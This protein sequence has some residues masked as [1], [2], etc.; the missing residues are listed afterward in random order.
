MLARGRPASDAATFRCGEVQTRRASDPNEGTHG[1]STASGTKRASEEGSEG[2]TQ[3]RTQ[4]ERAAPDDWER[5]RAIRLQALRDSPDA[6]W[7][8]LEQDVRLPPKTWRSRLAQPDAA[9]FIAR[10]D[11]R[12]AGIVFTAQ[13]EG[14]PGVAGLFG[15]W[16]APFA[17]R[18]GLADRLVDAVVTWGRDAGFE[19]IVLEVAD[20]NLPAIRLYDRSGFEPTGKLGRLPP[21]RSHITEH[22]RAR[23][24]LPR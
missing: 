23:V 21:P 14:R 16:V 1:V 7:T 12:D 10:L 20:G 8:L 3:E 17:R 22:E 13:F 6:F 2:S 5:V 18:L 24:L 4:V 19:R 9:T 11:E 15:M